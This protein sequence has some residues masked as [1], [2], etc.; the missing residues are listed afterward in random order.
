MHYTFK[1]TQGGY[2]LIE[3]MVAIA[4][5]LIAL[6]GPLTIAMKSLQTSYFAEEKA[7]ALYFA[8]EGVE[9]IVK[10]RN[11]AIIQAYVAGSL[12]ANWGWTTDADMSSCFAVTG[13]N[14]DFEGPGA[15]TG[16]LRANIQSCNNMENCRLFYDPFGDVPYHLDYG[17][18]SSYADGSPIVRPTKYIRVLH[19][20]SLNPQEVLI[21]STVYWDA[22]LFQGSDLNQVEL[23]SAVFKLYD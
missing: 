13:C 18:T 16:D 5:L 4:I 6:V 14:F 10:I 17:D 7:A 9:G 1:N 8:Q 23:H 3:V 21:T 20:E 11:D 12:S 19:L 2:S 15:T 22:K